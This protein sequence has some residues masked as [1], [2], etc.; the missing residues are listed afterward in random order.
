LS[1]VGVNI[2]I[3]WVLT[4]KA[5]VYYLASSAVSIETSILSNFILNELWTWRGV[6][7]KGA[8]NVLK[9]A[10]KFNLAYVIGLLVNMTVLAILT[11]IFHLY[12]IVSNLFGI[13]C[14]M[15]CNFFLSD[16]WVWGRAHENIGRNPGV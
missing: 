13:G 14:A 16:K 1:G 9:R 3:L 10:V 2:G 12:Y 7:G 15:L 11:E 5:G 6:G 4:E 8:K